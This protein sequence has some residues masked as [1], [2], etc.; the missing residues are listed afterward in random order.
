[1]PEKNLTPHAVIILAVTAY[2]ISRGL[3]DEFTVVRGTL[4]MLHLQVEG[5]TAASPR[6][7]APH[8]HLAEQGDLF[9]PRTRHRKAFRNPDI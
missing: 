8:V 9:F 4:G 5:P 6:M 1:M 7:Y 2:M 3:G